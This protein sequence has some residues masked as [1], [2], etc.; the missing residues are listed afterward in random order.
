MILGGFIVFWAIAIFDT[1]VPVGN[2]MRVN[3]LGLIADKQN[4]LI[5]GVGLFVIGLV[6]SFFK[7]NDSVNNQPP[8]FTEVKTTSDSNLWQGEKDI[9]DDSYKLYLVKKYN[10]DK[11]TTLEKY[12]IENKLFATIE[13]ALSFAM[14]K[15]LDLDK[16]VVEKKLSKLTKK[17]TGV[18]GGSFTYIEFAD[19]SVEISHSS[20]LVKNFNS[21]LEAKEYFGTKA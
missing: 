15:D 11:N 10:I 3:N 1:S 21:M 17:S 7:K 18:I 8:N 6:I 9:N 4:Y 19:G 14:Q 13:D 2:G 12:V 16:R 20:G 5:F